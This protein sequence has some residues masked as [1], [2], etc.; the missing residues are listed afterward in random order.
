MFELPVNFGSYSNSIPLSISH[1]R[2]YIE[3][4][5][6]LNLWKASFTVDLPR[7]GKIEVEISIHK[8]SVY[9]VIG[10][11]QGAPRTELEI[12]APVLEKNLGLNDL[13]LASLR[14]QALRPEQN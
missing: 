8:D 4:I 13:Q 9:A 1:G 3:E 14:F 6:E 10:C 7:T 2:A 5:G 12:Q 11:E